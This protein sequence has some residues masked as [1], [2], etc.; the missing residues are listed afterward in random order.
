VKSRTRV[1]PSPRGISSGYQP[2][3]WSKPSGSGSDGLRG[4]LNQSRSGS[5]RPW[6]RRGNSFSL[7]RMTWRTGFIVPLQQGHWRGSPPQTLRMRLRQ[8]GR[9]SR[10]DCFGGQRFFGWRLGFGKSDDAV[11]GCRDVGDGTVLALQCGNGRT[12]PVG[13]VLVGDSCLDS[14]LKEGI[15]AVR[16]ALIYSIPKRCV[17]GLNP[18]NIP[19]RWP[20]ANFQVT[21]YK[22]FVNFIFVP[23][24]VWDK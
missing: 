21:G 12:L 1:R 3:R 14:I 19:S 6:R 10:A 20:D 7:R 8:R 15:K 11:G 17:S 16:S 18:R 5:H 22:R 2:G 4:R 13:Q 24:L 9:M 23:V